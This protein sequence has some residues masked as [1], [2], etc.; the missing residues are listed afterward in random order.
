M[1]KP[2]KSRLLPTPPCMVP[3][4]PEISPQAQGPARSRGARRSTGA[5]PEQRVLSLAAGSLWHS[6]LPSL[7]LGST[8][9]TLGGVWVSVYIWYQGGSQHSGKGGRFRRF[10]P[11][12][13][14]CC[15]LRG[16]RGGGGHCAA[17]WRNWQSF[18]ADQCTWQEFVWKWLMLLCHIWIS[19][20]MEWRGTDIFC[21][22]Q[23]V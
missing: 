3:M 18:C 15:R 8:E 6:Y 9:G 21:W 1:P 14:I 5:R 17:I 2:S 23:L 12:Q 4:G 10:N 7:C 19:S 20:Y 16:R 11:L 13:S 22:R